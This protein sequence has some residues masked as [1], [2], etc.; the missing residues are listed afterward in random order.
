MC[1]LHRWFSQILTIPFA[2]LVTAITGDMIITSQQGDEVI[3]TQSLISELRCPFS[4][5]HSCCPGIYCADGKYQSGK[6]QCVSGKCQILRQASLENSVVHMEKKF[7]FRG[8]EYKSIHTPVIHTRSG[9]IFKFFL[10]HIVQLIYSVLVSSGQQSDS[11]THVYLVFS[12]FFSQ[13]RLLQSI[14]QSSL[15]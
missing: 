7:C 9:Q 4:H 6:Q 12:E 1:T 2:D 5:L 8:L 13:L 11:V 15:C 10:F 14:E 3:E